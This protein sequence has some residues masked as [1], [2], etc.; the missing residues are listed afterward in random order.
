M[1]DRKLLEAA[2]KAAGHGIEFDD[3]SGLIFMGNKFT[4][5]LWNPLHNDGDALRLSAGLRINVEYVKTQGGIEV[6]VN[7][8]P[9]GRGDCGLIVE[10]DDP[11]ACARRAIVRAAAA[12]AVG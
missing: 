7:C 5:V 1:N 4:G 3:A 11:T 9:V 6:G 8:W 10:G 12:M 2:A